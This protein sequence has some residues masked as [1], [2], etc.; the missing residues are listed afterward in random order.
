MSITMPAPADP[1]ILVDGSSSDAL[2]LRRASNELNA[3]LTPGLIHDVNNVLTGIYFNLEA[4]QNL[5][6]GEEGLAE[7]LQEINRGVERIKEVLSRATQIHL[8]VAERETTYHDLGA[9]VES[10]LDL[11][12]VV[13][14]RT[15]KIQFQPP[16]SE[17]HVRLA[18]FPFRVALLTIASRLRPFVPTGR[19]EIPFSVL[20]TSSLRETASKLGKE[21]PPNSVAVSFHLPCA[22]DSVTEIDSYP[23]GGGVAD[24]SLANA[25]IILSGIG[26]QL[27]FWNNPADDECHVLLV[28]PSCDLND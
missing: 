2:V 18:E 26:G 25:E 3:E 4:C 27:L 16:E 28:L 1:N 5:V 13:F 24:I 23:A 22:I 6:L 10:E 7:A 17:I 9:L 20:T 15:A 12:R 11:L 19:I 8:N 14:P 21:V